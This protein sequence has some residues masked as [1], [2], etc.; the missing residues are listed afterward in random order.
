MQIGIDLK[1]QIFTS[2]KYVQI[3]KLLFSKAVTATVVPADG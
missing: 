2:V 3:L 1:V